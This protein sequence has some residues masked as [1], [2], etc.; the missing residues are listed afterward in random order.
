MLLQC[1]RCSSE[2]RDRVDFSTS[3]VRSSRER[4][5]AVSPA[6]IGGS[7]DARLLRDEKWQIKSF[8]VVQGPL[9]CLVRVAAQAALM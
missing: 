4:R 6:N 7:C 3:L 8:E 2:Q 9:S 5:W 1:R